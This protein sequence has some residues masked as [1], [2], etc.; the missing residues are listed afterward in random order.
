MS[1]KANGEKKIAF[2]KQMVNTLQA[3]LNE[4]SKKSNTKLSARKKER[5]LFNVSVPSGQ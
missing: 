5:Q 3:V 1:K 2:N 4:S